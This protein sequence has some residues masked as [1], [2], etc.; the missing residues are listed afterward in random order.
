MMKGDQ[1]GKRIGFFLQWSLEARLI[2]LTI[3]LAFCS[4]WEF[5]ARLNVGGLTFWDF[6]VPPTRTLTSFFALLTNPPYPEYDLI[7]HSGVTLL[8]AGVALVGGIVLAVPIGFALGWWRGLGE[9]FTPLLEFLRPTPSLIFFPILILVFGTG[10]MSKIMASMIAVSFTM[11]INSL[12]GVM[13]VDRVMIN[14]FRTMGASDLEILRKGVLFT[15]LPYIAS[16]IRVSI[17]ASILVI[18][19]TEMIQGTDGLGFV[20]YFALDRLQFDH[21]W[22]AILATSFVG[23]GT[24]YLWQYIEQKI[25]KWHFATT[26]RV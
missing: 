24:V 17:G 4:L 22:S 3:V 12:Y 7:F 9:V 25:L 21:M 15:A 8:R 2:T 16:G 10:D 23:A 20:I 5:L 19:S 1:K 13:S 26:S 11:V 14:S 18:V 6:M